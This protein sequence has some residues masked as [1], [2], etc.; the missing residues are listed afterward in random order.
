M[1]CMN[2]WGPWWSIMCNVHSRHPAPDERT[3]CYTFLYV[4]VCV[5]CTILL[6]EEMM[7]GYGSRAKQSTPKIFYI[8]GGRWWRVISLS[9]NKKSWWSTRSECVWMQGWWAWSLL[10]IQKQKHHYYYYCCCC[11]G[12]MQCT[13]QDGRN[14]RSRT[15]VYVLKSRGGQESHRMTAERCM[16]CRWPGDVAHAGLEGEGERGG[17]YSV[18]LLPHQPKISSS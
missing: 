3:H 6:L 16:V 11:Y 5:Y 18:P 4:F 10:K 15:V 7:A 8:D 12:N 2:R 13:L 17:R 9:N 1:F 14:W